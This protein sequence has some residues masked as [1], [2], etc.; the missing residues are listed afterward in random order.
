MSA[1]PHSKILSIQYYAIWNTLINFTNLLILSWSK[2]KKKKDCVMYPTTGIVS[3]RVQGVSEACWDLP[4]SYNKSRVPS[5]HSYA[6]CPVHTG[7]FTLHLAFWRSCNCSLPQRSKHLSTFLS[8]SFG[9]RL[10]FGVIQVFIWLSFPRKV[11]NILWQ[12][13]SSQSP[14]CSTLASCKSS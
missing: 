3:S 1:V 2:R 5:S 10:T 9:W 6:F 8:S 4:A 12:T 7:N 14:K 13:V 11:K